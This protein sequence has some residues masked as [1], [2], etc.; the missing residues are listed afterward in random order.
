MKI[1]DERGEP[2]SA[3]YANGVIIC[4]A[5]FFNC[6]T[7]ATEIALARV[8]SLEIAAMR[9]EFANF[10]YSWLLI[11]FHLKLG[12]RICIHEVSQATLQVVRRCYKNGNDT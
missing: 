3:D 7:H 8:N 2:G 10:P 12:F 5:D 6:E 4:Y 11:M 1:G 9:L